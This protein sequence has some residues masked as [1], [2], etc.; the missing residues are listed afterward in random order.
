MVTRKWTWKD[1]MSQSPESKFGLDYYRLPLANSDRCTIYRI[2]ISATFCDETRQL[3]DYWLSLTSMRLA[4]TVLVI[5][6]AKLSM[7]SAFRL[8]LPHH[9]AP[10]FL[11]QLQGFGQMSLSLSKVENILPLP[12]NHGWPGFMKA[13]PALPLYPFT[14]SRYLPASSLMEN[15]EYSAESHRP[16]VR[17]SYN[18]HNLLTIQGRLWSRK[19]RWW[20]PFLLSQVLST[21][22]VCEV[23]LTNYSLT[24]TAP[25]CI[26]ISSLSKQ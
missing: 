1:L 3:L 11:E 9:H 26:S 13:F 21:P 18:N 10:R 17:W 22:A 14:V 4:C 12:L 5:Q 24:I 6:V 2:Q 7:L 19:W 20:W 8:H 16:L 25:I 23:T 15:V